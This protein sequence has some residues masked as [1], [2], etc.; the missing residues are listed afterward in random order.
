M[1]YMKGFQQL[2]FKDVDQMIM[3]YEIAQLWLEYDDIIFQA[4][5]D[6]DFAKVEENLSN[7]CLELLHIHEDKQ[8]LFAKVYFTS[9][10]TELMRIQ[11]RKQL[12]HAEFVKRSFQLIHQVEKWEN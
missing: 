9:I 2:S 6:E 8:R 4:L 10:L 7:F 12:L 1:V 11:V 3:N 5:K